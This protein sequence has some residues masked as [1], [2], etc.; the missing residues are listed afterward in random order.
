M[1]YMLL[2]RAL[3]AVLEFVDDTRYS[4]ASPFDKFRPKTSHLTLEEVKGK[5][6]RAVS[7]EPPIILWRRP[8]IEV[9]IDRQ[10]ILKIVSHK[11]I[12]K[13]LAWKKIKYAIARID[14]WNRGYRRPPLKRPRLKLPKVFY[15]PKPYDTWNDGSIP[16]STPRN[17]PSRI[18]RVEAKP[19]IDTWLK[20]PY[21]ESVSKIKIINRP[22]QIQGKA[23]V[24]T[25]MK[26]ERQARSTS[27]KVGETKRNEY[28]YISLI[29]EGYPSADTSYRKK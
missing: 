24:D 17:I 7:A 6:F 20:K 11:M 15:H 12:R 18:Q 16:T 3:H 19:R 13:K 29:F 26:L 9:P 21:V 1:E 14:C 23:R 4:I 28:L 8:S 25:W 2:N 27:A 5:R 10:E 22:I